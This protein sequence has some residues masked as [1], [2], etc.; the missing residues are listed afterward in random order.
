M[1]AAE[2]IFI[3]GGCTY[4]LFTDTYITYAIHTCV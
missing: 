4:S 1:Y 2:A 3:L